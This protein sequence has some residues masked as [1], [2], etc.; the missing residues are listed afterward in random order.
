MRDGSRRSFLQ[1]QRP[2]QGHGL[3]V[4]QESETHPTTPAQ[5]E[6]TGDGSIAPEPV[7]ARDSAKR[8][9]D[10]TRSAVCN[11]LRGW[12]Q[13]LSRALQPHLATSGL[14]LLQDARAISQC[15]MRSTWHAVGTVNGCWVY[16]PLTAET[17]ARHSQA[18][19]VM[20]PI[21]L[22]EAIGQGAQLTRRGSCPDCAFG[23][24]ATNGREQQAPSESKWAAART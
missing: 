19:G 7:R 22:D 13:D 3:N 1:S 2:E 8:A 9:L 4:I 21:D 18:P 20:Q 11:D 16:L 12:V 17:A 14:R 6:R 24:Q 23:G 15:R 5:Y 10:T